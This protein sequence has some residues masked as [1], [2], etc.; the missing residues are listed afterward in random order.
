MG[1]QIIAVIYYFHT[2]AAFARAGFHLLL[3]ESENYAMPN[4]P[5]EYGKSATKGLFQFI[6]ASPVPLA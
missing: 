6:L 5:E 3:E 1:L 2:F 4:V